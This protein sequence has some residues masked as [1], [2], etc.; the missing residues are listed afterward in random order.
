MNLW[1]IAKKVGLGMLTVAVPG[2]GALISTINAV[3]PDDKK[4]PETATGEDV[5]NAIESLPADQRAALL[6]KQYDIEITDIKESNQTLRVALD[7]DTKNP[8]TTRPY[9]AKGS[10][11]VVAFVTITTISIWSYGVV[12]DDSVMIQ[13]VMDG[14]PFVLSV[15]APLIILLH[16]YFGILKNEH[17]NRLD[18]ANGAANPPGIVG[19]LTAMFKR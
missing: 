16:G 1:D 7:A 2:A 17:K 19:A 5:A 9:I 14:W 10:F 11:L 8:H 4:L 3:L 12:G 15:I 6:S 18:A 13:T